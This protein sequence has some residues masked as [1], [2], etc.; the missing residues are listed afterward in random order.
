MQVSRGVH[1]KVQK[2]AALR[3]VAGGDG[4]GFPIPR[5]AEGVQ[6]G[7]GAS[8]AG[9]RAHAAVGPAEVFG[10]EHDGVDQRK[11]RDPHGA[12]VCGSAEGLRRPELLGARILG[13]NGGEERGGGASIQPGP[14]AGRQTPRT[15]GAQGALSA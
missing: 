10:V 4:T 5:G 11:E 13:V 9:P 12:S 15:T 6:G 14:G 8:D 1:A 7:G 3:A 2:E